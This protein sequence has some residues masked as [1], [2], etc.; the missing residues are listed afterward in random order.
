MV[1]FF[2]LC[3]GLYCILSF[4]V[5]AQQ[6]AHSNNNI[7]VLAQ[8]LKPQLVG[9]KIYTTAIVNGDEKKTRYQDTLPAVLEIINR[10]PR[11]IYSFRIGGCSAVMVGPN[12]LLTAA[13]CVDSFP[14]S[15]EPTLTRL[16]Y[17]IRDKHLLIDIFDCFIHPEYLAYPQLP[18]GIDGERPVRSS[19]DVALCTPIGGARSADII[20][21]GKRA[22]V[23]GYK[24]TSKLNGFTKL[25]KPRM[26]VM[27]TGTGCQREEIISIAKQS[28]TTPDNRLITIPERYRGRVYGEGNR[29]SDVRSPLKVGFA[30]IDKII[31]G[32]TVNAGDL[33]MNAYLQIY[34]KFKQNETDISPVKLCR[35]DSGGP[36]FAI[37]ARNRITPRRVIGVNS[38]GEYPISNTKANTIQI[39]NIVDLNDPSMKL[40]F[41][42]FHKKHKGARICGVDTH[43]NSMQRPSLVCEN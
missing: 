32:Q 7:T 41:E 11:K 33:D 3:L 13:H 9:G 20:T 10:S 40:F 37:K 2:I 17:D 29:K 30:H 25:P 1:R 36:L 15:T 19:H 18:E 43:N 8:N 35:G 4:E 38:T 42:E 22:E 24:N 27:M 12:T 39:N 23:I 28:I 16:Q 21:S 6:P 31:N 5:F 26:Q 34:S 14:D